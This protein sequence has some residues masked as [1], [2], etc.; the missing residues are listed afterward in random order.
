MVVDVLAPNM[1]QASSNHLN[2]LIGLAEVSHSP[3]I[4]HTYDITEI[5]HKMLK[6][7]HQLNNHG[8]F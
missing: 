3:I 1:Y 6:T 4:Y 2:D 5:K 7:G 8:G